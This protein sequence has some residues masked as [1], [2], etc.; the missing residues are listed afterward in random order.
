MTGEVLWWLPLGICMCVCLLAVVSLHCQVPSPSPPLMCVCVFA[1]FTEPGAIYRVDMAAEQPAPELFRQTKLKVLHNPS[2]YET[3]QVSLPDT[4]FPCQ[5]DS[6]H[7]VLQHNGFHPLQQPPM[8]SLVDWSLF[9]YHSRVLSYGACMRICNTSQLTHCVKVWGCISILCDKCSGN[10]RTRRP[11][12]GME[13][14]VAATVTLQLC[15]LHVT[16]HKFTAGPLSAKCR[17]STLA[18][19]VPP[20]PVGD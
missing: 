9:G 4:R 20:A 8:H 11:F 7:S 12:E 3:H 1:G 18:A 17:H 2:D 16:V 19:V 14:V 5:L 10:E 6:K 15:H 13:A